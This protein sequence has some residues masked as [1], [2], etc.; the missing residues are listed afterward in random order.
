MKGPPGVVSVGMLLEGS[1]HR[2]GCISPRYLFN[3]TQPG[4]VQRRGPVL[5]WILCGLEFGAC[6]ATLSAIMEFPPATQPRPRAP[7]LALPAFVAV[8]TATLQSCDPSNPA[9]T[10]GAPETLDPAA[11]PAI[12]TEQVATTELTFNPQGGDVVGVVTLPRRQE[13]VAVR[14]AVMV[15]VEEDELGRASLVRYRVAWRAE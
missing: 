5:P 7:F 13:V 9:P 11:W 8:A 15:A 1:N 6:P 12:E 14:G 2:H 10:P 4:F 3:K